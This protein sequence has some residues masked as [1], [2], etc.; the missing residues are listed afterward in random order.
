VEF[1]VQ[2]GWRRNTGFFGCDPNVLAGDPVSATCWSSEGG[3]LNFGDGSP[4]QA[5]NGIA[6]S[7]DIAANWFSG[8]YSIVHT[9][10]S[11]NNGG[12]PWVATF[13]TCC[14]IGSLV[15]AANASFRVQALVDLT[16]PNSSPV[17][18]IF[19]IVGMEVNTLN[20]IALPIGDVDGDTLTCRLATS[21]ES[22]ISA[23]PAQTFA[24]SVSA[25]TC[26]VT[27]DTAGTVVGQ[28]YAV[29]IIIEEERGG[30]PPHGN[31]ALDF[32]IQ[33]VPDVGEPPVCDVP[34]TPTGTVTASVGSPYTATIQCSDVDKNDVLTLN[35]TGV[36]AGAT[37]TPVLPDSGPSP[38]STVLNWTPV[39][40]DEGVYPLLFSCTDQLGLQVLCDFVIEVPLCSD[41]NPKT[42]G[43]W[44][45]V[46]QKAH[47][48]QEDRSFLTDE[49]CEDLN[50]DPHSD[51]CE[52]ARSQAAAA[53]YNVLSERVDAGCVVDS[54]G[55]SVADALAEI[56]DLI[57]Q[58]TN[59][60]CKAA[61]ALAAGMNE[62]GISAP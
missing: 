10:P 31:V 5:A 29:Q 21:A 55:G 12:A 11:P 19:P 2:Q 8:R 4:L 52:R 51:P 57:D 1:L 50:P 16:I 39:S 33:I 61:S 44:R 48:D 28:L 6:D 34:P 32:I 49:L 13:A 58:G 18:T 37:L 60:S 45:R 54:T 53:Q 14:R 17:S 20:N 46:C 9:Y 30:N 38:I 25:A 22:G 27:W 41:P 35:A 23:Q 3:S 59:I 15:N 40:G 24:L 42:Q 56:Q 47:P 26:I 7:V 36:P 43:F 62:G